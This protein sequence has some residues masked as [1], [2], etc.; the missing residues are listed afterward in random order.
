MPSAADSPPET[1]PEAFDT[2]WLDVGHGHRIHYWQSGARDGIP[3]VMLHG[4]PGSAANPAQNRI[5]DPARYRIVQ[6]DQRGCGRSTPFG[7]TRHNHTDALVA[8]IE[9]LRAHLGVERWF[10]V[11][12]SWGA[13]LAL[14]YAARHRE[15]TSGVFLRGTFLATQADIDWFFHGV[16]ALLPEAHARFMQ[17]V[18]RRWQ[19]SVEAWLDRCFTRADPRC[20]DIASALQNY[21]SQVDGQRV[22]SSAEASD[23]QAIERRIGKYRIQMH[24]LARR[25]FLGEAAVVRAASA[26]SGLPLAIVHGEFDRICRPSNAWQVHRACAGSRLAWAAQAGHNPWHPATY[27]LSRS[28]TDAFAASGDFSAWR[29]ESIGAGA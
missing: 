28:A 14:V 21:E 10:V 11:G 22:M 5:L 18:P 9:A 20:A 15:C 23:A 26:L 25:C 16:A 7:E 29:T 2:G 4:G 27:A 17:I 6:F 19:R 13:A 1:A 24:F 8:D 3:A 12:G